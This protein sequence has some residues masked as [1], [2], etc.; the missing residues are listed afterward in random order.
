MP[1]D[2]QRWEVSLWIGVHLPT[3]SWQRPKKSKLSLPPAL[4]LY[5]L[6]SCDQL[7]PTFSYNTPAAPW[8][9]GIHMNMKEHK[10]YIKYMCVHICNVQR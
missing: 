6:L 2:C 1:T 4:P 7:A 3:P 5:W 8:Y 10:K 9:T